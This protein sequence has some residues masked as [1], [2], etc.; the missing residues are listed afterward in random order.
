[1][2]WPEKDGAV[3]AFIH[4]VCTAHVAMRV[5]LR[6]HEA[7]HLYQGRFHSFAIQDEAYYYN[8]MRYVEANALRAGLVDRAEN[9]EWSSVSERRHGSELLV[10]G[11]LP[12]PPNWMD[13]VNQ[14]FDPDE[15]ATL[16][17][18]VR[19]GRPYGDA[20]WVEETSRVLGLEQ[21]LHGVGRT[22]TRVRRSAG[23]IL[24]SGVAALAPLPLPLRRV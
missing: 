8:A 23:S 17:A 24:P 3:S 20:G 7:G 9:W 10:P 15:L 11:P 4:W 21:T 22:R 6:R 5:R 14:G 13:L 12:L 2:V 16:R 18:S 1:V 19:S